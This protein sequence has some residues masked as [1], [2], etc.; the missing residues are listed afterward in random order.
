MKAQVSTQHVNTP[1][2]LPVSRRRRH[3]AV[4]RRL[5]GREKETEGDP[6]RRR[7]SGMNWRRAHPR[8]GLNVTLL[9]SRQYYPHAGCIG[10]GQSKGWISVSPARASGR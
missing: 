2:E 9:T 7:S 3:R 8:R 6:A 10:I 1:G 4:D 5:P